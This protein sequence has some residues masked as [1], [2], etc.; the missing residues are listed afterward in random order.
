MDIRFGM[1]AVSFQGSHHKHDHAE[2]H[3]HTEGAHQKPPVN[4]RQSGGDSFTK[5]D[6]R[7][8][9]HKH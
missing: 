6:T 8:T 4:E 2:G 3:H 5:A 1:K 9:H 7:K